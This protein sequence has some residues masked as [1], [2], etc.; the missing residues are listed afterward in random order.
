MR[1]CRERS[2]AQSRLHPRHMYSAQTGDASD[3]GPGASAARGEAGQRA[4]GAGSRTSLEPRRASAPSRARGHDLV[5]YAYVEARTVTRG[6]R[7][8]TRERGHA[9]AR[10]GPGAGTDPTTTRL[11]S[12]PRSP[13]GASRSVR[14]SAG[15]H[16]SDPRARPRRRTS[17]G[18]DAVRLAKRHDRARLCGDLGRLSAAH[19]LPRGS[20]GGL[21]GA[22]SRR[23]FG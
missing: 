23:S 13:K 9:T 7:Q 18:H 22:R 14:S 21:S 15:R 20:L 10:S 19:W 8:D 2:P 12:A 5:H 17:R 11:N 3:A 1:S 16:R 4:T 6:R